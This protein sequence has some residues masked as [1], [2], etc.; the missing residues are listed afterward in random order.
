MRAASLN[1]NINIPCRHRLCHPYVSGHV[2]RFGTLCICQL[3]VCMFAGAKAYELKGHRFSYGGVE[4]V[5]LPTNPRTSPVEHS[6]IRGA[7]DVVRA[8]RGHCGP[9]VAIGFNNFEERFACIR[10]GPVG[11]PFR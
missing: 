8:R 5:T 4:R 1:P 11:T 3:T 7:L 6:A 10:V 2:S 9:Y